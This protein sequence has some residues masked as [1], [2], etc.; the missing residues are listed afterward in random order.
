MTSKPE[1]KQKTLLWV[2]ALIIVFSQLGA[3]AYYSLSLRAI[4]YKV[5]LMLD[6]SSVEE[7]NKLKSSLKQ[8]YQKEFSDEELKK[9]SVG[10]E[11]AFLHPL[12]NYSLR[13]KFLF[14]IIVGICSLAI[15]TGIYL[16][17]Q[18]KHKAT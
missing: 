1:F 8:E 14:H 5:E 6:S 4:S 9:F 10:Y 11:I 16:A 17:I 2:S 18:N 15:S 12:L 7:I 13:H 3:Y